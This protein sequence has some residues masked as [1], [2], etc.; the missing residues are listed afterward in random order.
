MYTL[1]LL[2]VQLALH[3]PQLLKLYS[4]DETVPSLSTAGVGS[5]FVSQ[6]EIDS[7]KARRE[8]Q[9]KAAYARSV[10][11]LPSSLSQP[12]ILFE[13]FTLLSQDGTRTAS[14]AS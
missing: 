11:P 14:A 5:R 10:Q 8:E 9:W 6:S 4:M 7:A 12:H 13:C 2:P 1:R 3:L